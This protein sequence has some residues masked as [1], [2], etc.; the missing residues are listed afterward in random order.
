MI[1]GNINANGNFF[2]AFY[3]NN[4]TLHSCYIPGN[5]LNNGYRGKKYKGVFEFNGTNAIKLTLTF[6]DGEV[7]SASGVN[8]NNYTIETFTSDIAL[9]YND[10]QAVSDLKQFS[11]TVDGVPVFSGNK[12]GIDTIKPDDF[13]A[14]SGGSLPTISDDGIASG[15]SSTKYIV[16]K[17]VN[18]SNNVKWFF[19]FTT[20]S[21]L[22][23]KRL[24]TLGGRA[25]RI[26]VVNGNM[27]LLLVD[28][29]GNTICNYFNS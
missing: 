12:T 27:G 3:D 1:I 13:S 21:A 24:Y 19:K 5:R 14:P 23:T 22:Q 26:D 4:S 8:E 16:G 29:D 11:I 2:A 20:P 25:S 15:F 10:T 6:E 18:F 17:S 28:S 7:F 9:F